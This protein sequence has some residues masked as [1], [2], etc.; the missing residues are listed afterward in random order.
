LKFRI[1]YRSISFNEKVDDII[2]AVK[3]E[4]KT[5][6]VFEELVASDDPDIFLKKMKSIS[7]AEIARY[8]D[9]VSNLT[10]KINDADSKERLKDKIE[11]DRRIAEALKFARDI[12]QRESDV[13]IRI[14]REFLNKRGNATHFTNET[15][16]FINRSAGDNK[17]THFEMLS[18]Y[19][20][21]TLESA[22]I[23]IKVLLELY[24]CI[25]AE[26]SNNDHLTSKVTPESTGGIVSKLNDILKNKMF[27]DGYVDT[28]T[29]VR[30][31]E[32][33]GTGKSI[34]SRIRHEIEISGGVFVLPP[35]GFI[36]V[37]KNSSGESLLKFQHAHSE[38]GYSNYYASR[39]REAKYSL[40]NVTHDNVTST[41]PKLKSL[42][43]SGTK[44]WESLYSQYSEII[45]SLPLDE[46]LETEIKQNA[47][48][49]DY[50]S[51]RIMLLR[52][53]V[54]IL[55]SIDKVTREDVGGWSTAIRHTLDYYQYV[56]D[57]SR[58]LNVPVENVK[59]IPIMLN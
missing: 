45:K 11:N 24:K 18:R 41:L 31:L 39:Q 6:E 42:N 25:K 44:K 35:A 33:Y 27:T 20:D 16:F 15:L 30:H 22:D 57:I 37:N 9:E 59:T 56:L 48:N 28:R 38:V 8:E 7:E 52:T 58:K 46:M 53:L 19:V 34:L 5:T 55:S 32:S 36:Y 23:N 49:P 10:S 1:T 50:G 43:E 40:T 3:E 12:K 47:D 29:I 54:V 2:E 14:K 4:P 13:S 51:Y 17:T 26:V 21:I